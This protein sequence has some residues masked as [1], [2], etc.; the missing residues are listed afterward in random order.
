MSSTAFAMQPGTPK[1]LDHSELIKILTGLLLVLFIIIVLSWVVKRFNVIQLS[2]SKG[3]EAIANMTLGPKE[4]ITLLK[5]GNRY[6]LVGIG[7]A[8]INTLYDFGEQLPDGFGLENKTSFADLL[9][10][11]VR[12][13]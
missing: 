4:K 8:S 2:S 13:S 7:S 12:K 5:V 6:L 1:V 3:F 9:K 11:V 10:S